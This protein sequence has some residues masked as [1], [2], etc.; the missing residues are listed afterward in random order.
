M[1]RYV[2][3][4][5]RRV[6][7]RDSFLARCTAEGRDGRGGARDGSASADST[8]VRGSARGGVR[9]GVNRRECSPGRLSRELKT[10]GGG[11]TRV[12][13]RPSVAGTN[14][15][16]GVGDSVSES[17]IGITA[18]SSK[19][20]SR[21]RTSSAGGN[22]VVGWTSPAPTTLPRSG[23]GSGNPRWAEPAAAAAAARAATRE[24]VRA[25]GP[26]SSPADPPN[27]TGESR[28]CMG[29]GVDG[30]TGPVEGAAEGGGGAALSGKAIVDE[31]S[32]EG[33]EEGKVD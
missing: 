6:R 33:G 8:A 4:H 16:G 21:S 25:A 30:S 5:S 11:D 17:V 15:S 14:S 22:W 13:V 1:R 23:R 27:V 24:R 9:A 10:R 31:R 28:P 3:L 26:P 19:S 2:S 20:G 32:R 29:T 18:L 7:S 12:A